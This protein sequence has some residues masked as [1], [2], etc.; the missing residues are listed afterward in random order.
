VELINTGWNA[1]REHLRLQQRSHYVITDGGDQPNVVPST[2]A[3]WYYFRETDYDRI[4]QL[5]EWGDNMA[6]G[7][8][9]M[10]GTTFG[11]RVLGSAWPNHG[12]RAL[13]EALHANIQQVGMP[14]WSE[15]DQQFARAFQRAMGA[16]ERGL[17]TEVSR[18]LSGRELVPDN[19]KTGGFSDDIG[20]IMWNVP[21]A[22]LSFPSNVA[23]ATGHHW[24]AAVAGATPVAHKGATQGAKVH[25]MTTLD[26]LLRPELLDAARD[27]FENVQGRQRRYQPLIRPDDT[28]AVWL[29]QETMDRFRPA[30]R[31][32]Y[33]DPTRYKSYLEQL[34]VPYPPPM[35][36]PSSARQ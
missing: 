5:W 19:Q 20:D 36:E 28:P 30:L 18:T 15:A 31:Q 9:L 4:T 35:P 27:Y 26:L 22:T 13:S 25:A 2:A 24:S 1:R 8:A 11:S 21:T 29:N 3:V 10:T 23:G 33:Y 32:H 17:G 14:E 16:P 34:N 12:N 6:R 7:A